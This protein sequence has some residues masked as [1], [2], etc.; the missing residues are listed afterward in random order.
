MGTT[1]NFNTWKRPEVGEKYDEVYGAQR[2]LG[3]KI[4]LCIVDK[5]DFHSKSHKPVDPRVVENND[6]KKITSIS[7]YQSYIPQ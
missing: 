3:W 6:Q 7:E 4:T 2:T 5:S 1:I